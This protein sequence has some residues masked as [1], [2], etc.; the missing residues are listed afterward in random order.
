MCMCMWNC[1]MNWIRELTLMLRF[2]D[3]FC[4]LTIGIT[5]TVGVLEGTESVYIIH[6]AI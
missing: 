1:T 2:I 3:T 6:E 4:P 5:D